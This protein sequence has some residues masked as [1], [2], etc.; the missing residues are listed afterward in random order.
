MFYIFLH[1]ILKKKQ[2]ILVHGN[3]ERKSLIQVEN[4]VTVTTLH[5]YHDQYNDPMDFSPANAQAVR[6]VLPD[7]TV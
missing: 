6:A 4:E 1:R 2:I 7:T 5:V 3:G